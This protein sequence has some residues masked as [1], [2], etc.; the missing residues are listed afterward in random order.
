LALFNN[1]SNKDVSHLKHALKKINKNNAVSEL[2]WVEARSGMLRTPLI[3]T[4]HVLAYKLQPE[5]Y[6]D[7]QSEGYKF[8]GMK[9]NDS[10]ERALNM[11]KKFEHD[12][13]YKW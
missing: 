7:Y 3:K 10:R 1:F 11:V 6:L 5:K 12:L 8:Y 2:H 9:D 4:L 13:T